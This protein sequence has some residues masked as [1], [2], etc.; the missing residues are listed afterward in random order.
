M[1][2]RFR[3][4]ELE[5]RPVRR[6][7]PNLEIGD[8]VRQKTATAG[9][10]NFKDS[11]KFIAAVEKGE[12]FEKSIFSR[13]TNGEIPLDFQQRKKQ[14]NEL[15]EQQQEFFKKLNNLQNFVKEMA[16]EYT[17]DLRTSN[18]HWACPC[19]GAE[20]DEELLGEKLRGVRTEL[21]ANSEIIT[22]KYLLLTEF[23]RQ[24]KTTLKR[25]RPEELQ[26]V[27]KIVEKIKNVVSG[28]DEVSGES[29]QKSIEFLCQFPE[30]NCFGFGDEECPAA[31]SGVDHVCPETFQKQKSLKLKKKMQCFQSWTK[32]FQQDFD[33]EFF[34]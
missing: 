7:F 22:E 31:Y 26:E 33:A 17:R 23:Q 29:A 3:L 27:Q 13:K 16:K 14:L 19:V 2:K 6:V 12:E 10:V 8:L 20:S 24:F 5:H 32:K 15:K 9:N 34:A 1:P 28:I 30:N 25:I 11:G 18:L 21:N 4:H